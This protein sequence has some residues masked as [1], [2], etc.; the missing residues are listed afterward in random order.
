[1]KNLFLSDPNRIAPFPIVLEGSDTR[2]LTGA[3][4]DIES[5]QPVADGFW[6][7]DEFGPYILKFDTSGR[8]TDVIPTTL[9]GK[10]VLSPDN[11]L[12]RGDIEL[13]DADGGVAIDGLHRA[14]ILV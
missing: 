11:P 7:G 10:P 13:D 6:L 14:V 3:D 4:F 1:V 9:D 2:Y 12:L 5:I 8:L